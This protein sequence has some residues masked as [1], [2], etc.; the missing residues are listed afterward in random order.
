MPDPSSRESL[1]DGH[2]IQFPSFSPIFTDALVVSAVKSLSLNLSSNRLGS[3]A[4]HP[5]PYKSGTANVTTRLD[6]QVKHHVNVYVHVLRS[7]VQQY[8]SLRDSGSDRTSFDSLPF[9]DQAPVASP[10]I[11]MPLPTAHPLEPLTLG[12]FAPQPRGFSRVW[13]AEVEKSEYRN[14]CREETERDMSFIL[15]CSVVSVPL[16]GP[17]DVSYLNA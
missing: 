9:L 17:R 2:A 5:P 13:S 11:L 16:K 8:P 7:L 6:P 4:L 14:R 10:T 1:L 12:A 3:R 15:R